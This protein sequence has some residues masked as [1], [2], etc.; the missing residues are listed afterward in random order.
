M[1]FYA[2][3]TAITLV[4]PLVLFALLEPQARRCWSTI[5]P[6]V[7]MVVFAVV[8]A[9]QAIW[10]LRTSFGPVGFWTEFAKPVGGLG[11]LLWQTFDFTVNA[12]LLLVPTGLLC[13][14]LHGTICVRPT[15]FRRRS[16]SSDASFSF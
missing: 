8:L 13:M 15:R 7:A 9:P 10:A 14:I 6:Y 2:K 12:V 11:E 3:Y 1:A 16:I 5:G 4:V